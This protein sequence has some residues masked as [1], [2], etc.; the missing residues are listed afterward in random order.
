VHFVTLYKNTSAYDRKRFIGGYP[1]AV[2]Q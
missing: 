1:I 2:Q